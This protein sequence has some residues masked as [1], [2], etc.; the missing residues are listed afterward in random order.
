M[1]LPWKPHFGIN[2]PCGKGFMVAIT[3]EQYRAA[4]Q[5]PVMGLRALSPGER[6]EAVDFYLAHMRLGHSPEPALMAF[7]P[8]PQ[9]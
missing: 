2:C 4:E 7:A 9:A 1:D 8:M 3:A 6:D 5:D